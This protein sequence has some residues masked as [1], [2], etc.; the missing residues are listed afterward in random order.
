M[1]EGFDLKMVANS[2][3]S[4]SFTFKLKPL[5]KVSLAAGITHPPSLV[6]SKCVCLHF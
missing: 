1:A 5:Q 2:T 4:L 6:R 3:T